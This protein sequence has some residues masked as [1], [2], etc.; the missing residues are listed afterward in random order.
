MTWAGLASSVALAALAVMESGAEVSLGNT[1]GQLLKKSV[2]LEDLEVACVLE[3]TRRSPG[4]VYPTT[5]LSF[6]SYQQ[7]TIF[8]LTVL[9]C[10]TS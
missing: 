1:G 6:P 4:S 8:D 7:S 9:Q 2:L 10:T 3:F 5:T